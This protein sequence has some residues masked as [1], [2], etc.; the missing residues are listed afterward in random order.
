MAGM[1]SG[2]RSH[3]LL[4]GSFAVVAGHQDLEQQQSPGHGQDLRGGQVPGA[5]QRD[6]PVGLGVEQVGRR[7]GDGLADHPGAVRVGDEPDVGEG[8]AGQAAD[9]G[10]PV[11]PAQRSQFFEQ[12]S[13]AGRQCPFSFRMRAV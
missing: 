10:D 2:R 7:A 8:P 1:T 9:R 5:A 13:V 6:E 11:G 4:P 12:H 3:E